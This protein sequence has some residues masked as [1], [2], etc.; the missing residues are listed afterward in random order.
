MVQHMYFLRAVGAIIKAVVYL[1]V[2]TIALASIIALATAGHVWATARADDRSPADTIFVLGAAQYDGRPSKWL[3]ARLDHAADLY[4]QGTAPVIVTVGGK[5]SGD[6]FTEAE[7]GKNYLIEQ[8]GIPASAV[9][10]ID[11]GADTLESAEAFEQVARQNDWHTS[12]IVTDPPH[13][14]RATKM[15]EEHGVDAWGSPTRQGPS[16]QSRA[17]QFSSIIHETGGLLYYQVMEREL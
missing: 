4:D 5:K 15:V 8:R 14:L 11:Q 7:A 12:V 13:T 10:S 16:V 3:A 9:V 17:A 1:I 2:G 6:R